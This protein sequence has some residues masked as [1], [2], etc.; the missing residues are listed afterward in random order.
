MAGLGPSRLTSDLLQQLYK[1][2]DSESSLSE[3]GAESSAI[4]LL[5]V[6]NYHLSERRSPSQDDVAALLSANKEACP[7]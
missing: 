3:D 4:K 5:M 7:R 2:F 1:L 6:W